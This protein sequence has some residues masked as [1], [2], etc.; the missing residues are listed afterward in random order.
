MIEV[1]IHFILSLG[2]T[3]GEDRRSWF[4]GITWNCVEM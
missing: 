2:N 4:V 3:I 1:F